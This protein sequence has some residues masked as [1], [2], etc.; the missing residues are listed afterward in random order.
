M[1]AV[2]GLDKVN[3]ERTYVIKKKW[4]N[5]LKF[6]KVKKIVNSNLI[7]KSVSRGYERKNL[8]MELTR[9]T[10]KTLELTQMCI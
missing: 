5:Y 8:K 9:K 4:N 2:P 3:K 6:L 7:K 10:T 1:V